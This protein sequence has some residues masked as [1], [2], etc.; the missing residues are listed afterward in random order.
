MEFK[1]ERARN[2]L[3]LVAREAFKQMKQQGIGGNMVFVGS[4]ILCMP[5]KA[6][7]YSSVKA[8]ETHL[9]RCIA[10]KAVSMVFV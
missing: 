6:T 7:A 4:K 2:R 9:A 5:G 8:L 3:L 10:L 1:Y